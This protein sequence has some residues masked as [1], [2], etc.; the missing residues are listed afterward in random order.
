MNGYLFDTVYLHPNIHQDFR[1][2]EMMIENIRFY[3]FSKNLHHIMAM[4]FFMPNW[5]H[6]S[7]LLID[8]APTD[9]GYWVVY[10]RKQDKWKEEMY[11][12]IGKEVN[13][14]NTF[15]Y[16]EDKLFKVGHEMQFY[17]RLHRNCQNYLQ[18]LLIELNFDYK[19]PR[20]SFGVSILESI[21]SAVGYFI[22]A[23]VNVCLQR[24][25]R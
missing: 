12:K 25:N 17:D 22:Y 24:R 5:D 21:P 19:I 8:L 16:L 9:Q 23:L 6:H 4:K 11:T 13:F 7:T 2:R 18:M 3:V 10:L 15:G 14:N 1:N 20:T